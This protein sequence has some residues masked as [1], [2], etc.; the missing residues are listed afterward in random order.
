MDQR[1]LAARQFG[2]VAANYLTS[3]VHATGADLDR[4]FA[5]AQ[6]RRPERALDL[7][8]GAGHVSFALARAGVPHVIAYDLSAPMLDVVQRESKV[9][10]YA[11]IETKRGPAEQLAFD[12]DSFDLLAT[13]FS[14]HHWSSVSAAIKEMARVLKPGGRLAVIDVTSPDAPLLDTMLQTLEVLR[15]RSHVRNYRL[16]EWLSMLRASGLRDEITDSWK[17]SIE[18]DSWVRR[19]GTPELRVQAL[20]AVMDDLPAEASDYFAVTAERSFKI[21]AAWIE[22]QKPVGGCLRG[23]S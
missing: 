18:F 16:K 12:D 11:A 22:V 14:A 5:L 3:A 8:C 2:D 7:G 19:I 9:R 4:L 23:A 15:D 13:R 1:N 10:G 17:L 6:R 21:D 20:R